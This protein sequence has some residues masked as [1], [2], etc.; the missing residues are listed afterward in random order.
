MFWHTPHGD[1]GTEAP[2]RGGA[3][4][5]EFQHGRGLALYYLLTGYG[6]ALDAF[7]EVAENA[8][9]RVE[10]GPGEPGYS[11]TTGDEARAPANAIAILTAAYEV[12]MN[13]SFLEAASKAVRESSFSSR[14]YSRPGPPRGSVAPW[15]VAMLMVSLGRYLDVV[16]RD[17]GLV[18]RE[19]LDS[20]LGY[21]DWLLENAYLVGGGSRFPHFA[22]RWSGSPV[23]WS[24]GAGANAWMLVF[25]DAFT[26]AWERSGDPRYLEVARVQFEVG[27]RHFWYEDC[28]PGQ[29]AT[30]KQHAILSTSGFKYGLVLASREAA[31]PPP[32]GPGPIPLS[33]LP[34]EGF[35]GP[36]PEAP[37][38]TELFS[39]RTRGRCWPGPSG[40]AGGP[41]GSRGG[42]GLRPPRGWPGWASWR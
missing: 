7:M 22:Y 1:P 4:S 41:T 3:P 6:P 23:D 11:G 2:H 39:Q 40:G 30:G 13:R 18:D 28:P 9:W 24:P 42:P 38:W 19:A 17:L 35:I 15:Q 27:S 31:A 12:T 14:W 33:A 36:A 26:Y 8:L 34:G 29:F 21:A 37:R 25:S 20:L 5:L 10:N 16:E 32:G